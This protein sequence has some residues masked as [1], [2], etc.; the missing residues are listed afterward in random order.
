MPTAGSPN[1]YICETRTIRYFLI[2]KILCT[3]LW[4]L[5]SQIPTRTDTIAGSLL[6]L[7]FSEAVVM[8]GC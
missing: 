5:T 3:V 8:L 6:V 2:T 4:L 7:T 1:P